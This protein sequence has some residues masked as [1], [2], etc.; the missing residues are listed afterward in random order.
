MISM[1]VVE[2]GPKKSTESKKNMFGSTFED[3]SGVFFHKPL[4]FQWLCGDFLSSAD[5]FSGFVRGEKVLR[6][7]TDA[8]DHLAKGG[9]VTPS[10]DL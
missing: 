1:D 2:G 4:D 8:A 6:V 5:G 3:F 10:C 7:I 9:V